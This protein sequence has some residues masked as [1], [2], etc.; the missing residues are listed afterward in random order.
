M[1]RRALAV[2]IIALFAIGC[3]PAAGGASS[4]PTPNPGATTTSP[5][6]T[7]TPTIT[8]APPTS[9][10][11]AV[12]TTG[13]SGTPSTAFYLRGWYTQSLA[14]QYTFTWLPPV[15]IADGVYLNGNVAVPAIYPGPLMILPIARSITD[16]GVQEI[17]DDAREL[18][19][20]EGSG[21]FTGASPKPGAKPA[22]IELVVDGVKHE[23]TGDPSLSVLCDRGQCTAEPGTPEAFTAFWNELGMLD[24]WLDSQ[25]GDSHQYTPE[26][27][28][29]LLTDPG[30]TS[31]MSPAPVLVDWPLAVPLGDV[32]CL[33]VTGSDLDTILPV[34]QS[35]NQLAMF[36]DGAIVRE[37]LVSVLVPGGP[38]RCDA[39]S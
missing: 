11:S 9:I 8:A 26:R 15:T 25:L 6:V 37:P 36:S 5:S 22:Q 29:M 10:P 33:T 19:L 20:L 39:I 13:P 14:P 32:G 24:L 30:D 35:A 1:S 31:A 34:L 18:G 21:D 16:A 2:L 27:I 4:Q 12:P 28:S 23:L 7:A 38:S 17:V 3:A